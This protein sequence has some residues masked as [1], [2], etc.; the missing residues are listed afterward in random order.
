MLSSK[1]NR[2]RGRPIWRGKGERSAAG[3]V[4]DRRGFHEGCARDRQAYLP[5]PGL[6]RSL[7][8]SAARASIRRSR[9]VLDQV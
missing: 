3:V 4:A 7:A 9:R 8:I 6:S 1:R 2:N 5:A